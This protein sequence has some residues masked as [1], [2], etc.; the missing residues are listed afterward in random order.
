ML[1]ISRILYHFKNQQTSL[2]LLY[3]TPARDFLDNL[4]VLPY[5]MF[6]MKSSA[7][8]LIFGLYAKQAAE[9]RTGADAVK[10]AR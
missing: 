8:F 10:L 9:Y 4:V 3:C 6:Q 7:F 1:L 5:P 2:S